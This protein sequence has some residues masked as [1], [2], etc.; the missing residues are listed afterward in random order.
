M[1]LLPLIVLFVLYY[2]AKRLRIT[3]PGAYGRLVRN[4]PRM[5]VLGGLLFAFITLPVYMMR[6]RRLLLEASAGQW[7]AE[8]SPEEHLDAGF[9]LG[10]PEEP[11]AEPPHEVD[12]RRA[13]LD[14]RGILI[15]WAWIEIIFGSLARVLAISLDEGKLV[16]GTAAATLSLVGLLGA[17]A[18]VPAHPRLSSFRRTCGL[19]RPNGSSLLWC[20]FAAV[21]GAGLVGM[22]DRLAEFGGNGAGETP[23]AKA[24]GDAGPLGLLFFAATAVLI[25][26]VT[27]EIA[28]RGFL[29]RAIETWKGRATSVVFV[30]LL[31]FVAHVGQLEGYDAALLGILIASV[32]FTLL[33]AASGSAIPSMI[34]HLVYNGGLTLLPVVLLAVSEPANFEY[35][36]RQGALDP[37]D[38]KALLER[39]LEETPSDPVALNNLA[40]LLASENRDLPLALELVEE[41]LRQEPRS[42]AARDTKAT[43]LKKLG[44][45]QEA[46]AIW[47]ELVAEH[48]K[49]EH[50]REQLDASGDDASIVSTPFGGA[51]TKMEAALAR[52]DY[53]GAASALLEARR[54][55]EGPRSPIGARHAVDEAIERLRTAVLADPHPEDAVPLLRENPMYPV[56]A[57]QRGISGWIHLE[58]TVTAAGRTKDVVVLEAEPEGLFDEAAI[59]A[60][61]G[62]LYRPKGVG[63]RPVDRE[64][65][66]IVLSFDI[67]PGR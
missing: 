9:D 2:D 44:R 21:V 20:A 52:G 54:N 40:W 23:L 5:W 30:V 37:T 14:A 47:E 50:H 27:E 49:N 36:L 34:A 4:D 57:Q 16:L 48:P 58:F 33:R 1:P 42:A 61:E 19:E 10:P 51:M 62:Y 18:Y 13:L 45:T 6:R 56:E 11:I 64:K 31:F 3:W 55:S 28:Y 39:V 29:F 17:V 38:E 35:M 63:G 7:R 66:Q 25:A 41:S 60:V 22:A 46:R 15:A 26:P 53:P 43:L 8:K 59:A 67:E 32:A 24:M 12:R 65:I